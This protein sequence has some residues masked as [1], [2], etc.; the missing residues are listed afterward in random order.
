VKPELDKS[1]KQECSKFVMRGA[2]Y[3]PARAS[4]DAQKVASDVSFR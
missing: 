1:P 4:K 3:G 2:N